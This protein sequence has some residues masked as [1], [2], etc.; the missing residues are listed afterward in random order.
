MSEYFNFEIFKKY[1][2]KP[3][4]SQGIDAFLKYINDDEELM[5]ICGDFYGIQKFIFDNLTTEYAAKILRA[6]SAFALLFNEYIANLICFRLDINRE[7]IIFLQASKFEILVP[8]KKGDDDNI[9]STIES[10]QKAINDYFK[11][12]FFAQSGMALVCVECKKDDFKESNKYKA[13]REEKI[14]QEIEK[15]KLKKFD[16]LNFEKA[17]DFVLE[18]DEGLNNENLCKV[19]NLRIQEKNKEHCHVCAS[20]IRLGEILA[21]FQKQESISSQELA[22]NFFN[23][24][25]S[26]VLDDAI[27]SYVCK[28]DKEILTFEK[29]AENSCK[30]SNTGIKAL[31]I[32]K[33]DVDGMGNFIKYSNVTEKF[34]NFDVFSKSINNFF[35]LYVPKLMEENFPNTYTIFA[36]GD[37]LFLVGAWDEILELARQIRKDF[38]EFC[39]NDNENKDKE[40]KLSI[41]FGICI[42]NA[43][44]PISYLARTSES[45]LEKAKHIDDEENNNNNNDKKN[46]LNLFGETMKWDSYLDV[47]KT[48]K[49]TFEDLQEKEKESENKNTTAFLYRLLELIEMAKKVL[50]YKK[51]DNKTQKEV[52]INIDEFMQA[53]MWK[54]KL[55]YTF[56]RNM[57]MEKKENQ[58]LLNALLENIGKHPKEVKAFLCEYIYKRRQS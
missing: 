3:Y 22:L 26:L 43:H 33:A 53:S 47:Y 31:G 9:K 44:T 35:S 25:C 56:A 14:P 52:N 41:S 8:K 30:D 40:H 57:D 28:N 36:G 21:N 10:T 46:A 32:L 15:Q 5:L 54:S 55:H 12:H 50:E 48:L 19:C 39:K 13:L 11:R 7:H 37:D 6:K 49:K 1:E 42:A 45:L 4:V 58:D 51:A 29:L 20:F 38:M 24:S 23:F 16:F 17:S 27:K 18:I 2:I 34:K